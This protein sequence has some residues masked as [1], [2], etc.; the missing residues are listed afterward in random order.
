MT[1]TLITQI[2]DCIEKVFDIDGRDFSKNIIIYPCGDVGIQVINILKNIYSVEPA[3]LIDTKKCK[4][5]ALI[6]DV[7][8]LKTLDSK[9][10]ILMLASTNLDIYS[11]LR[12]TAQEY[13]PEER[14]LELESMANNIK[15]PVSFFKTKIGRYSYGP[16]CRN[17]VLIES[18]GS[19]CSFAMGVD[20][21]PNHEMNCITT[22][23]ILYAGVCYEGITIDYEN[24]K[25][26]AW[27]MQGISPK[28]I[29]KKR[30]RS[31]IGNDV[32]LGKNVTITNYAN[33]GN[34]VIVAAGAVITK[35]VPDYAVVAGVPARIIRY[36]YSPEQI[37]ALNRIAWWDWTDDEIR[38]RF[39][40]FYLP[41][42]AFIAK[43]RK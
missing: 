3:F 28:P 27:Y 34:G 22:H 16:I 41:V 14:I 24:F 25:D 15:K 13:F 10:Y 9:E 1:K 38:E 32:W 20:V 6:H 8:F 19:F 17:H 12:K 5:N 23:P 35:D 30:G 2:T 7:S 43:Y 42:D 4:Y 31:I 21:V 18:I 33:I 26:A 36:R 29:V 39:E 11:S 40:D 37:E